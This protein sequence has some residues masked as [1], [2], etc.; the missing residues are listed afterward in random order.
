M[1]QKILLA[2]LFTAMLF[3][4]CKEEFLAPDISGMEI[5]DYVLNIG[6]KLTLAPNITNLKGNDYVWLLDGKEVA[7]GETDY[8]FTATQPGSYIVIFKATNKGGTGEKAFKILVEKEIAIAFENTDMTTPK[9]KVLEIKPNITG[10][11]RKD[12]GYEWA[13]GD[14]I[15]GVNKTLDFISLATDTTYTLTLKASAGKQSATAS[16]KVK[17]ENA[18]YW[19]SPIT[20]FDFR[21]APENNWIEVGRNL[22]GVVNI[23]SPY[24]EFLQKTSEHMKA[25]GFSID[26]TRWGTYVVMGF[27]HTVINLQ[28]KNDLEIWVTNGF[29][30]PNTCT[31]Y[32]SYDENKNGKP[33]DEWYELK[34]TDHGGEN[35]NDYERTYTLLESSATKKTNGRF[36]I[37]YKYEIKDNRNKIDTTT[38]KYSNVRAKNLI[39]LFP[40]SYFEHG[41]IH[42]LQS[43]ESS[44]TIKGKLKNINVDKGQYYGQYKLNI[45]NA[46][47]QQ[48]IQAQLPGIDFIKVQNTSEIYFKEEK[49][50]TINSGKFE[51]L[52][53][54]HL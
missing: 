30:A 8:T 34:T 41:E 48:G 6:D 43:W 12:Y 14:S 47:S 50:P 36:N 44:F 4:A 9:L 27:D 10:P 52:R 49:T 42:N 11:E 31:F 39:A 29:G 15:I 5:A 51:Y 13:I 35:I 21:S 22:E 3:T 1:K 46:V 20:L 28:G 25:S 23:R 19:S 38:V 2:V 40:G 24:D 16:C 26:I 18:L 54:L 17:V 7:S 32:V 53:D 45:D 37:M 33:D